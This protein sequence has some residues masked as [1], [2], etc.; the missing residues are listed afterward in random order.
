MMR[1][2]ALLLA[3]LLALAAPAA[4]QWFPDEAAIRA[5]AEWLRELLAEAG[6]PISEA[7]AIAAA[8]AAAQAALDALTI[9][10][11]PPAD[12]L[13]WAHFYQADVQ[14]D[15]PIAFGTTQWRLEEGAEGPVLVA[16]AAIPAADM[17][18]EARFREGPLEGAAVEIDLDIDAPESFGDVR[19]AEL[20]VASSNLLDNEPVERVVSEWTGP[21]SLNISIDFLTPLESRLAESAALSFSFRFENRQEVGISLALGETGH[22]RFREAIALW[23][24][25]PPWLDLA[26][27]TPA[28]GSDETAE[29]YLFIE[30]HDGTIL[31][32]DARVEWRALE[33]HPPLIFADVT[34][35]DGAVIF[36]TSVNFLNGLSWVPG[37]FTLEL[38]DDSPGHR[39]HPSATFWRFRFK[40]ELTGDGTIPVGDRF[41]GG[42]GMTAFGFSPAHHAE[43]R[44]AIDEANWFEA[45]VTLAD[46][47]RAAMLFEIGEVGH[48]L[49]RV[50]LPD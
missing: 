46:G 17:A 10:E 4:A 34:A 38:F 41:L 9:P 39:E 2:A 48:A 49:F 28:S 22:A 43:N 1:R 14:A 13:E 33:F 25:G 6:T 12:G 45:D 42:P 19:W 23:R 30:E 31:R 5:Q 18:V 3:A 44:R 37:D 8:E 36:S 15:V 40:N 27:A 21:G 32:H 35:L 16:T 7:E 47:R 24:A 11:Q 26:A 29:A 20:A 50:A